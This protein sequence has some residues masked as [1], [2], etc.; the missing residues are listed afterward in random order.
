LIPCRSLSYFLFSLHVAALGGLAAWLA[1]FGAT[2]R[3][4][5]S[6]LLG[7]GV[8]FFASY[9]AAFSCQRLGEKVSWAPVQQ[10]YH[11]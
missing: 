2:R 7:S 11:R 5:W 1:A 9:G 4:F 10:L 6:L 8:V 3:E